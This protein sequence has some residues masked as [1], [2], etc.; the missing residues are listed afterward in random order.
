[1]E[2]IAHEAGIELEPFEEPSQGSFSGAEAN[3][4]PHTP[5]P[6]A[7]GEGEGEEEEEEDSFERCFYIY[8]GPV[9]F[10]DLQA[11]SDHH[12]LLWARGLSKVSQGDRVQLQ[13][14]LE[15][16]NE[17]LGG[18]LPSPKGETPSI[19]PPIGEDYKGAL[20]GSREAAKD[21]KAQ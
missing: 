20:E 21:L 13:E 4:G 17:K 11:I 5:Q 7:P 8:G 12:S 15:A 3:L 10:E 19:P 16:V 2:A 1:M 18:E 6:V 14:L 9:H